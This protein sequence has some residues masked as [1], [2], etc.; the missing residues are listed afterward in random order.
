M[1]LLSQFHK[2]TT[3][4]YAFP[5]GRSTCYDR[6]EPVYR[7]GCGVTTPPQPQYSVQPFEFGFE[8]PGKYFSIYVK[9]YPSE[10]LSLKGS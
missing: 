7:S 2:T 3:L 6:L 10:N 5:L 1:K 9:E 4:V 8:K